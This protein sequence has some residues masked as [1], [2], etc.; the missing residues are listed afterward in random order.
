M[1]AAACRPVRRGAGPDAGVNADVGEV[2]VGEPGAGVSSGVN[3]PC[4]VRSRASSTGAALPVS[5]RRYP[6]ARAA[7]T[8]PLRNP[9]ATSV[10]L[11]MP[12]YIREYATANG[13]SAQR[14]VTSTRTQVLRIRCASS[15]RLNHRAVDAPVCPLG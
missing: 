15:A 3:R 8:A 4:P 10:A 2:G 5:R 7:Q 12:R 9:A 11:C 1:G 6:Y 13:T 14:T